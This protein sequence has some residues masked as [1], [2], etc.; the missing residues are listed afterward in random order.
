MLAYHVLHADAA[1]GA[2][3][4]ALKGG[5]KLVALLLDHPPPLGNG[6]PPARA[7]KLVRW[8][9]LALMKLAVHTS[10]K[11]RMLLL[12]ARLWVLSNV[13]P[14][15]AKKLV[16][17]SC[18]RLRALA[19]ALRLRTGGLVGELVLEQRLHFDVALVLFL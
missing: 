11:G 16:L 5:A 4:D 13:S 17:G 8:K 6:D 18:V 19:L 14:T 7:H 9:L 2:G 15:L 12:G 10:P 1:H 3:L